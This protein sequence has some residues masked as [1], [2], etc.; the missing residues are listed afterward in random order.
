VNV[1]RHVLSG[2]GGT[3]GLIGWSVTGIAPFMTISASDL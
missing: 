1:P 2:A 3:T